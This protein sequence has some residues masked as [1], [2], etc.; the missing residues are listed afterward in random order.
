MVCLFIYLFFL[1]L[2]FC[3]VLTLRM[4]FDHSGRAKLLPSF[5]LFLSKGCVWHQSAARLQG[6][7]LVLMLFSSLNLVLSSETPRCAV[8]L[9]PW[10]FRSCFSCTMLLNGRV[11][12]CLVLWCQELHQDQR[13]LC[14][15]EAKAG[16][17]CPVQQQVS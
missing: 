4:I 8:S 13:N 6:F 7:T 5:L 17:C 10:T 16:L 3:K 2:K 11:T 15:G 1:E 14:N 12:W 9:L